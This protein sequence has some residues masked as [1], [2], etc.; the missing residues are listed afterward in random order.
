[1]FPPFLTTRFLKYFFKCM[2]L[3]LT[4]LGLCCCV[5]FSLAVV[6]GPTLAVVHGLLIA[7]TSLVEHGLSGV[8]ASVV[9]AHG[10]SSYGS[11]ALQH[12]LNNCGTG[13][14]LFHSICDIPGPGIEAM[15]PAFTGGFFTTESPGKPL[16][17]EFLKIEMK[18]LPWESSG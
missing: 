18:G 1:M 12:R 5:G 2:Y 14:Q 7:V 9:G 3:F 4:M 10:L 16:T 8:Q 13:A 17:T 11:W 15:S 6:I